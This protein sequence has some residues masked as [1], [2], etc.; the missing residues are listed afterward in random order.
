M[1]K[2][3]DSDEM[4]MDKMEMDEMDDEFEDCQQDTLVFGETCKATT[5]QRTRR[6]IQ[7]SLDHSWFATT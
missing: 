6:D 5:Q 3:A 4:E 1:S 7:E 2:D